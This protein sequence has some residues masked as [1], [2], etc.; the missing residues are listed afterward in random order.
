MAVNN[1]LKPLETR[2]VDQRAEPEPESE[3]DLEEVESDVKRMTEK[4]LEYRSTIPDQLK[5]TLA[6]ILSTHRPNWPGV[7]DG[8]EPGP[9]GEN[10]A[11]RSVKFWGFVKFG[12][13]KSLLLIDPNFRIYR[14]RGHGIR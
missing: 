13:G 6:S 4:I 11:G 9:S 3:E 2:I 10:N 7:N 5:T 14:F 8:L 12:I 1:K